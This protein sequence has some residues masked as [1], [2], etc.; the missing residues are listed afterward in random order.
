MMMDTSQENGR[1][2]LRLIKSSQTR[3]FTWGDA[4][5][6][7]N[8]LQ[9]KYLRENGP[10]R[11]RLTREHQELMPKLFSEENRDFQVRDKW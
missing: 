5:L 2:V 6:A 1:E 9:E 10:R 7:W 4:M 3:E 11:A 8:Q